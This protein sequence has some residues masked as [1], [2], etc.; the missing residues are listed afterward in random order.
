[1]RQET[2][3]F[4]QRCMTEEPTADEIA[5]FE[6]T[7][8]EWQHTHIP[9]LQQFWGPRLGASEILLRPV[10]AP[11]FS[12]FE[13]CAGQPTVQFR[14]SGTTTGVR[15][16]HSL[17][18][19][20]AYN[21]SIRAGVARLPLKLPV[22]HTLTLCPHTS[23]YPD[24]SLAHMIHTLSPEATPGFSKSGGVHLRLCWD[25]LRQTQEALF[26]PATALSLATLLE[27]G[28]HCELPQGSVVMITGG[29][30]GQH[31]SIPETDLHNAARKQLGPDAR[32]IREY[33]MTELSSQ[34]WDWGE[35]YRAPPWLRVF[36]QHTNSLGVGQLCFVDLA[37][38][39]SC[40]AIETHDLGRVDG[41]LVELHGRIPGMQARGCSLVA[42]EAM[43]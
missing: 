31:R 38:W 25:H 3:A 23:E 2:L 39:G 6:T 8:L 29:Y 40:M 28:N 41:D 14:T 12:R 30:K 16:V 19:I 4:L 32:I 34:L 15:G 26:L 24:S 13:F 35:G 10:P 5:Q 21:L 33:G 27:T 42:E 11:L 7:L 17:P 18:D 9:G 20:E 1:M 36:T 43:P 22:H 37:N